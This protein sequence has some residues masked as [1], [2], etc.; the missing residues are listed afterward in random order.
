M[1]KAFCVMIGSVAAPAPAQ[2]GHPLKGSWSGDW[3]PTTT[4]RA[5]S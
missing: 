2:Y 1:R 4:G 3:S 5:C